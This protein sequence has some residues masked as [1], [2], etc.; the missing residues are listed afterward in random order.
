LSVVIHLALIR[1]L[2]PGHDDEHT[3]QWFEGV[4]EIGEPGDG[5]AERLHYHSEKKPRTRKLPTA[6]D[7]DTLASPAAADTP[8]EPLEISEEL[9]AGGAPGRAG[10][11]LTEEQRYLLTLV[12]RL[13]ALKT[14]PR[15]S[16][17]KEE[18]ASLTVTLVIRPDGTIESSN[19]SRPSPFVA[20]NRAALKAV[21]KLGPLP[22][23][24]ASWTRAIRVRI[25]MS[26][27]IE[28]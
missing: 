25:P 8:T 15:Q 2:S 11:P 20:L 27:R 4:I 24:P 18:E 3:V 14:Y 10:T 7:D 5:H 22:P 28:R 17:L 16:L 6:T 1:L 23:L 26:Y 12:Q 19:L 9:P 13:D 21:S